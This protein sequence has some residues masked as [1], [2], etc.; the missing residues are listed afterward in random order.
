MMEIVKCPKIH[1]NQACIGPGLK[2]MVNLRCE[3]LT[4]G[5]RI[6]WSQ[7]GEETDGDRVFIEVA[8]SIKEMDFQ[9]IGS[10][11]KTCQA[12][13]PGSRPLFSHDDDIIVSQTRKGSQEAD[14]TI[15]SWMRFFVRFQK[16]VGCRETNLTTMFFAMDDGSGEDIRMDVCE[17]IWQKD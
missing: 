12:L 15:S 4:R 3:L 17:H 10:L 5:E 11:T 6:I 13:N 8:W 16:N 9:D 2:I 7:V 14:A 1:P